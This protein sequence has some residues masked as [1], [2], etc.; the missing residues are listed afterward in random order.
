[1]TTAQE[2]KEEVQKND[3][4][5]AKFFRESSQKL[6]QYGQGGQGHQLSQ[7]MNAA[8]PEDAE[9]LPLKQ[10]QRALAK[11]K[12]MAPDEV[13][14]VV[15]AGNEI[16]RQLVCRADQAET[17]AA[18]QHIEAMQ[19]LVDVFCGVADAHVEGYESP[20]SWGDE[21]DY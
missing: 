10:A 7:S 19:L 4:A 8:E 21:T 12:T 2:M 3:L 16:W 1:M 11:L 18:N 13:G 15:D 6:Q 14:Q 9:V 5:L 20:D 17:T